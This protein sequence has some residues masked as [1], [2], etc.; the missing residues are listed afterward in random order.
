G[1]RAS[2]PEGSGRALSLALDGNAIAYDTSGVAWRSLAAVADGD[3][4]FR[5]PGL[6]ARTYR[7]EVV[8]LLGGEA[9][10]YRALEVM[11]PG[12]AEFDVPVARVSVVVR[13]GGVPLAGASVEARREEG[14]PVQLVTDAAG[15]A[16]LLARPGEH[17]RLAVA[18][19]GFER[20][21]REFAAETA[22]IPFDLAPEERFGTLVVRLRT[23]EGV[24]LPSACEFDL[25]PDRGASVRRKVIVQD[26]RF[27][28][29]DLEPAAYRVVATLPGNFLPAGGAVAV[30][31]GRVA[32]LSLDVRAG[33]RIVVRILTKDPLPAVW[34][35]GLGDY[36]SDAFGGSPSWTVKGDTL[37]SGLMAPGFY[38]LHV[39]AKDGPRSFPVDVKPGETVR[40]LVPLG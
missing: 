31:R 35:E 18:A 38:V 40:L 27:F 33:G 32:E 12:T 17:L 1:E 14:P 30:G 15:R 28:L 26:G 3:G 29:K 9:P 8:A 20:A 19:E 4:A 21:E 13:G 5:I 23:D 6:S 7:V 22:E 2:L 36:G 24:A 10:P 39:L 25:V 11:A 16:V 34:V 37:E